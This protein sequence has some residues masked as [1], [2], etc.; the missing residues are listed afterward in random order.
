MKVASGSRAGTL[1]VTLEAN[2]Q[3]EAQRSDSPTAS[4]GPGLV[5]MRI[6]ARE[7]AFHRDVGTQG[8]P[9]TP[10]VTEVVKAGT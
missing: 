5:E 8:D 6:E 3:T 7:K 10:E 4:A 9:L 1:A 2:G